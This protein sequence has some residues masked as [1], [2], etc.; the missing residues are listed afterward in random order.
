M[1]DNS[2]ITKDGVK[3]E[4]LPHNLHIPLTFYK[5]KTQLSSP[6][7]TCTTKPL[8]WNTNLFAYII[9]AIGLL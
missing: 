7:F 6:F 5:G 4:E 3:Q 8:E 9:I 2:S 1:G